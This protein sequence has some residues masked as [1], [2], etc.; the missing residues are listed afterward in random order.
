M[1]AGNETLGRRAAML[2]GALLVLGG[3][4]PARAADHTV[5]LEIRPYCGEDDSC[6]HGSV[7]NLQTFVL[8]AVQELNL[9]WQPT[10]ISFRPFI[11][12]NDAS[13]V[14]N[15]ID[16]C[17]PGNPGMAA[18]RSVFGGDMEL[19]NPGVI[20][21][22][23]WEGRTWCCSNIPEAGEPTNERYGVFCDASADRGVRGLGTLYAHELGHHWCLWHT[24]T[25]QD[26]E[27]TDPDAPPHDN[28]FSSGVEDTSPDP[29]RIEGY[30]ET[31]PETRDLDE[32]DNTR[33]GHEWC[34]S[35][36][37][38]QN[39]PFPVDSGS[40]HP[41]WCGS[42]CVEQSGGVVS[43]SGE[44]APTHATMSYYSGAECQGPY[45]R[46]GNRVEGLTPDSVDRIHWCRDNIPERAFADACA[47]LGGDS[48]SDGICDVQDGCPLVADTAQR[49]ADGDGIGDACDVCPDAPDTAQTDTD[50]DGR[51]DA[52][53]WDLDGDTCTN[54]N[55]DHPYDARPVTGSY[56]DI[57]CGSGGTT[58]TWEGTDSD[59][60]GFPNCRDRDD[61]NDTICDFAETHPPD[62]V[63]DL[64]SDGCVPG[65]DAC[66]VVPGELLCHVLGDAAPCPPPWLDCLGSGC[67]EFF[68]K[69]YELIN[70]DP[71][72]QIFESFQIHDDTLYVV[73]QA[74]Q[75]ISEAALAFGGAGAPV[76]GPG[77]A[78][79]LSAGIL[80]G[81]AG[82]W[83]VELWSREPEALVSVIG[84]YPESAILHR[85]ITQGRLVKLT[86]GTDASGQN[87][88]LVEASWGM[89]IA[90]LP[91]DSDGDGV[92]D[93]ADSCTLAPNARQ[94]DRDGDGFGDACQVDFDG[95]GITTDT[96]AAVIAG[97]VGTD[98]TVEAPIAEP[99]D[100]ASLGLG[101]ALEDLGPS[102][103]QLAAKRACAGADLDENRVIDIAD[104]SLARLRLGQGAGPAAAVRTDTDGDG[105][106]D[107]DDACPLVPL[108]G[109]C[110]CGDAGGDGVVGADDARIIRELLAG[111][112]EALPVPGQCNSVGLAGPENGARVPADC[113]IADPVVL[114]RAL[115]GLPP[116]ITPTCNLP[117][118]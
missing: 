89:G 21:L 79:S 12:P 86:P 24:M 67:V 95:D 116:A 101:S 11:H 109:G 2:A 117:A 107:S 50:G 88:L 64:H 110:Q 60:D 52:C 84:D 75:A 9:V 108:P 69:V 32:F 80:G 68:M 23:I 103:E 100:D 20:T 37:W 36:T 33:D 82:I 72:T 99:G 41:S 16:G 59:G 39:G 76:G 18:W 62:E 8:D 112:G 42:N 93:V 34:A 48:D 98:I 105:L 81:G 3:I 6:G 90:G 43:F 13:G 78:G 53:D 5:D 30:S 49:D 56:F 63:G 25:F 38:D 4:G 29:G 44:V 85:G 66:P 31:D 61:D 102:D 55:D 17:P 35:V 114:R 19:S 83:R 94:L 92:P 115:A 96:D 46:L 40:P 22:H 104:L 45:V 74:G 111:S 15:V 70:P 71:T 54:W 27:Q 47:A 113:D 58:S 118:W 65:P 26:F 57:G 1:G 91:P 87:T 106:L 51:G 77:A 97:C 73:P 10:G 14:Y 7:E 28:D